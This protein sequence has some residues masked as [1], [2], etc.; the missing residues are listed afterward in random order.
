MHY[1]VEFRGIRY[2]SDVLVNLRLSRPS[3]RVAVRID[4]PNASA[5]LVRLPRRKSILSVPA[6]SP[7]FC[8]P[9]KKTVGSHTSS[10]SRCLPLGV[11]RVLPPPAASF[12]THSRISP[13]AVTEKWRL[14][15]VRGRRAT[16]GGCVRRFEC[17][18]SLPQRF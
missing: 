1:G 10:S 4:K 15:D 17:A 12:C 5:I 2:N 13:R 16:P 6:V 18:S 7:W 14:S 11:E 8:V 3:L 9:P